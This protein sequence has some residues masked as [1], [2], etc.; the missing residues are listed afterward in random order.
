MTIFYSFS[1]SYASMNITMNCDKINHIKNKHF[2]KDTKLSLNIHHKKNVE[3]NYCTIN[4]Q[5]DDYFNPKQ[6]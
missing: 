1:T 6:M 4:I 2:T 3:L 5:Y